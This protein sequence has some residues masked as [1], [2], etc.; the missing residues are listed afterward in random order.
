M[1]RCIYYDLNKGVPI[2]LDR[3]GCDL[4]SWIPGYSKAR[5]AVHPAGFP[6]F[7][8]PERLVSDDEY[9]EQDPYSVEN[10]LDS[11]F[12]RRRVEVTVE[13]VRQA[14]RAFSD[15]PRIL[16]LGC[17]QGHITEQIRKAIPTS[18]VSGLDYSI[19]AIE[20]A[21]SHFP[22]ISFAVGDAYA[23]PYAPVQFHVVVCN[24]LW[25]HVPDPLTLLQRIKSLLVPGG[26]LLIS[27]PSRYRLSNL[28]RA[29]CGKEVVFMSPLHVTEY[30]VGQVKE[31]LRFGGLDVERVLSKPIAP[32]SLKARLAQTMLA[33]V[34]SMLGSHHQ[35]ESTVF[36]LARLRAT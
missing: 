5:F 31:Q 27:T 32:A 16:D 18:A 6:V 35:L 15:E 19:S 8:P 29:L 17:G 21:H 25:E 28:V 4:S 24:N 14:L 13:L 36:Y 23:S 3:D 34:I 2:D 9:R 30:S 10:N 11:P 12:H 1:T 22:E 26:F 20:Y 7:L 33:P